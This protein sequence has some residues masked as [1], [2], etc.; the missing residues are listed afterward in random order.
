MYLLSTAATE[1]MLMT[2]QGSCA[3]RTMVTIMAVRMAPLGNSHACFLFLR[4]RRSTTAAAATA[5]RS[6]GAT[7]ATPS[8][9]AASAIRIARMM[10]SRPLGVL[11]KFFAARRL[12]RIAQSLCFEALQFRRQNYAFHTHALEQCDSLRWA[13]HKRGRRESIGQHGVGRNHGHAGSGVRR[14]A[15]ARI[16]DVAAALVVA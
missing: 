5:L 6:L 13:K 7:T 10:V 2:Y 3:L 1:V 9:G 8:C 4:I 14:R 16:Q 12:R 11:K 15:R